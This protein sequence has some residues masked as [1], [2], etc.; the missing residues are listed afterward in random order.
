MNDNMQNVQA[1]GAG[2]WEKS[3]VKISAGPKNLP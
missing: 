3:P 2:I 1:F